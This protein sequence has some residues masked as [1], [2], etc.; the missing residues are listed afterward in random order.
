[1]KS[2]CVGGKYSVELAQDTRYHTIELFPYADNWMMTMKR[3]CEIIFLLIAFLI[4]VPAIASG[5][6]FKITRVYDGKTV[7]AEGYD[8]HCL[9]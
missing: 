1:M 2:C 5:G 4:I 8:R 9:P 7:R 6:Q 3:A